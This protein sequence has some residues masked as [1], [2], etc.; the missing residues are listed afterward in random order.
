[1]RRENIAI[2][3]GGPAGCAAAITLAR[4]GV[5]PLV[6]ERQ[7]ETGDALCG[8]FLSWRTVEALARLGVEARGHPATHLRLTSGTGSADAPLPGGAVGLSRR[9]MD[10][11]LQAQAVIAGAAFE[12]GVTVR[13][14]S[15]GTLRLADGG[16]LKPDTLLLATGKHDLRGLARPKDGRTLGLRLRLAPN[17][18][19]HRLI[20][21]R[22][23]LHLFEGG[24]AGL[25]VQE[26]GSANL[27]LAVR[28]ERLMDCGGDPARLFAEIGAE[29]VHLGERLSFANSNAPDAIAAIPYGWRARQTANTVYRLGDQAAVIP[30][31]AGEGN[32]IAL[33][34]GVAAAQAILAGRSAHDFQQDFARRVVGPVSLAHI[35]WSLAE[36]PMLGR[37][38]V[39]L[40]STLPRLAAHLAQAT[41][42]P[43]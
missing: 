40:L 6:L 26:D 10:T 19:L 42:V 36:R 41:R 32:G 22:I 16:T 43:Y 27:C 30:S 24:Y 35:L 3:G 34:S 31:L 8:G 28:K 9:A 23:E 12:R 2:V 15:E 20:N 38:G 25:M 18:T 39:V 37:S 13:E 5:R 1:M 29:N 14:M 7:S 21:D 11:A 33:A 17:A 4:Q